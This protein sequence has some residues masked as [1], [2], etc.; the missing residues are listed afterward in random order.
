ML[1]FMQN[2]INSVEL[3]VVTPHHKILHNNTDISRALRLLPSFSATTGARPVYTRIKALRHALR[4]TQTGSSH[5]RNTDTFFQSA[6][7]LRSPDLS[8]IILQVH[9]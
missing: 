1:Q 5:L 6:E 9:R 2:I 4:P 3:V 7:P 8:G